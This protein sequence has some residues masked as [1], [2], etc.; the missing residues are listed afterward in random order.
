MRPAAWASTPCTMWVVAD[1]EVGPGLN[2]PPSQRPL[3]IRER[4]LEGG[5]PPVRHAPVN[6]DDDEVC[7]LIRCRHPAFG[8]QDV[9]LDRLR[10]H[11]RCHSRLLVE[12]NR[13]EQETAFGSDRRHAGPLM[14]CGE[15]WR[16]GARDAEHGRRRA[17]ERYEGRTRRLLYVTPAA[18]CGD[19]DVAER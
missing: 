13:V 17:S 2:E 9:L 12:G 5:A 8:G 4:A 3:V 1:H 19:A 18:D 10:L 15:P 16:E 11:P 14:S 6:M 7:L